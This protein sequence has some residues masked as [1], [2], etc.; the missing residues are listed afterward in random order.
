VAD[1][2]PAGQPLPSAYQ[3]FQVRCRMRGAAPSLDLTAFRRRFAMA[4]AG[5]GGS[6]GWDEVFALA[7]ALPEEMLAPFL[8]VARSAREGNA[9]PTDG[10]L[11]RLYGTSSQT[12]ARWML[13][14]MEE[15]GL[16]V[17][18]IDLGGKRTIS[19]PHLGWQTAPA[20]ADPSRP[21]RLAR[22][23]GREAARGKRF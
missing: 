15:K 18:R 23:S 22:I 11:A 16:I 19:L 12:R 6:E 21:S 4:R 14:A 13:G 7:A 17:S 20:A 10:E 3:D 1:E 8:A 9:C 2:A 5:I